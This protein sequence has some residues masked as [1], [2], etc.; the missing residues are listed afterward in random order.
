M[1]RDKSRQR[2]RWWLRL[3]VVACCLVIPALC[4]DSG[5]N[6]AAEPRISSLLLFGV[7]AIAAAVAAIAVR[8]V[9]RS[10]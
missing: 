8:M 4:R 9:R 5:Y 3:L 10:Q 6:S 2:L 1:T 7:L